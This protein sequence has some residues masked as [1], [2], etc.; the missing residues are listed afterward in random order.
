MFGI[1]MMHLMG[2]TLSHEERQRRAENLREQ[3]ARRMAEAV[4]WTQ[5]LAWKPE[6]NLQAASW[7]PRRLFDVKP[8]SAVHPVRCAEDELAL[9]PSGQFCYLEKVL[10]AGEKLATFCG[11]RRGNVLFDGPVK[12][13]AIH[14]RG[15]SEHFSVWHDDPWMSMTPM[16]MMTLRSGTRLAKG[17]VVV[18]GLGLGHQLIEVSHRRQVT[19]LTLVERSAELV[20]WIYPRLLGYLGMPVEVIIGDA[21]EVLPQ[22]K[23]DVALVDIFEGYGNN[24]ERSLF[25]RKGCKIPTKWFWGAASIIA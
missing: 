18:A 20:D 24:N 25:R 19:H 1:A 15:W 12:I 13:P 17:R 4:P 6:L 10:P 3:K 11:S 22:L 7:T 5:T 9:S 2:S 23:A 14:E 8:A 16:E 21:Y